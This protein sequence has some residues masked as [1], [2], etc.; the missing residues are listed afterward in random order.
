LYV[1]L[2]KVKETTL[3]NQSKSFARRKAFSVGK[4]Q[5]KLS[6]KLVSAKIGKNS[7]KNKFKVKVK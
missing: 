2:H 1:F 3:G 6:F 5:G 4:A 7:H